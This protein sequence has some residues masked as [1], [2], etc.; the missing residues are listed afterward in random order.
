MILQQ[1]WRY[2]HIKNIKHNLNKI[3][4]AFCVC[5]PTYIIR[6]SP[7]VHVIFNNK[8]KRLILDILLLY[9]KI[10]LTP[11]SDLYIMYVYFFFAFIN[12]STFLASI[13]IILM[14]CMFILNEL[15]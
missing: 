15:E 8:F 13:V 2:L 9:L 4:T 6:S 7:S 14:V 11:L 12:I 10:K 5:N 3:I 1:V